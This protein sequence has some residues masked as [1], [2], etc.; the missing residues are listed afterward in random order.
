MLE[1]NKIYNM[2]CLEGMK[3]IEDN[4]IP[5]I[6]TDPPYNWNKSFENDNLNWQE[7]YNFL[8]K[9]FEELYRISCGWISVDIPRHNLIFMQ[10]IICKKFL[11]YDYFCLGVINAM[12][13]CGLGI[14]RFRLKIIARKN[15]NIKVCYK[16]SNYFQTTRSS[17]G[18]YT[19]HPTEK[20]LNGYKYIISMLSKKNDIILDPFIG[21]GTTAIAALDNDRNF[22]GFEQSKEYYDMSNKRILEWKTQQ[23]FGFNF[24][25]QMR[26]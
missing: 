3:L 25:E 1:L 2:D 20:N 8:S 13:N 14:D 22:I 5:L 9:I 4:S 21:S 6:N 10:Q 7:Y 19:G 23:R 26:F 16:R 17:T 24:K 11:F 18:K 15:K 12:S